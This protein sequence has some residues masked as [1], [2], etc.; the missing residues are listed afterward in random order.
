MIFA[1][2]VLTIVGC[3]AYLTRWL[4]LRVTK[5]EERLGLLEAERIKDPPDVVVGGDLTD[6]L[7]SFQRMKFSP[8]MV[9]KKK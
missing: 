4:S 5:L 2:T 1:A 9:K 7:A 6:R 3:G 8:S